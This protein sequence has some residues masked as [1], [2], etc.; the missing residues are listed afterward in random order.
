MERKI[1]FETFRRS[2]IRNH[3][4]LFLFLCVLHLAVLPALAQS[5]RVTGIV[6]DA[7]GKA[8][9]GVSVVVKGTTTGTTTDNEGR[10]SIEV[11]NSRSILVFSLIGHA[12]REEIVGTR[13]TVDLTLSES[14]S[15]LDEVVVI[16]YGTQKKRDVTGAISSINS[17]AIAERAPQ[18]VFEAIQG[19]IPGVVIAQESGRPGAS[20]SI[21]IRGIGTLEAGAEPLYVVDGAQGVNID[22]INPADIE[23]IE[24]L[25]D[26]ASAA[27]YGSAGGNGVIII[28]TKKGKEGKPKI[29]LRYFTSFGNLAHKVPQANAADRRLLDLKR[30]STG[31][32]SIP[33]DS[34]NP[35]Y[36][37][38]ND[39]QDLLTQTAVRHQIDLGISGGSKTANLYGSFGLIKDKGLIVNS[40]ADI[41][42]IRFNMDFKPNERFSFGS[43]I[44]GLYQRENRIDE[45]RTLQQAIQR[46][47]NF[48][49]WF[50]DG[51]LSG[52]IGGR[53][54]PLAE[55]LMDKNEYDIYD[56]SFYSYISYNFLKELKFTVDGNIR[57][58]NVHNLVFFP[59]LVSSANPLNNSIE[60]NSDLDTY[61]Q[62]QGYFNYNKSFGGVHNVTGVLGL[63][64]EQ[65]FSHEAEQSG[66]NLVTESVLTMNS[67]QVKNPATTFEERYFKMSYF[68]RLGYAYKGRYLINSNIRADAS[69]R[70]GKDNKWGI[71]PSA[72]IGWRFSDESF[73]AWSKRY[74][75][76]G[77]F[78]ISYGAIGND[79]IGPYDAIQRYVFGSNYYNGIS[80]VGPNTTFGNSKLAWESV[81]QFN[82][83]TD[84]TFLHGRISLSADYYNKTTEDL[85][86]SA[87]LP[88]NTGFNNVKV[89]VGS[90]QNKGFEFV[91]SGYPVRN[92]DFQWNV[93]YNMSINNNTVKELYNHTDLLPGS[94]NVWKVSE[95]GRLGDFYGY[96]ALGVYAYDQSN[97]WTPDYLHQLTPIF[98]NNV[99]SGYELD[100]KPYSGVVK[101]MYTNGL[102]SQGGDMIWQNNNLDSVIDDND[103]MILGN[104]QPKWVAGLNNVATYKNFTLSFSFYISW[105]GNIY[106][107][108]RAQLNLNATTNVTPEP[109]Y[110]HGAWWHQGDVTI[111]PIA[112]N[113]SLG[114]GRDGSSLYME[115]ATYI[116]LR[117]AKLS[118]E[119]P[120]KIAS[121][122]KMDAVSVFVF[123]NN[124]LTW[125][126]YKWYDPEISLG[127]ALTPGFDS[128]RFPRKREFG[129]GININF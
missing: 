123:G 24:V 52:L 40:W 64:G 23:S 85:L 32:T 86:Y 67:A 30:S 74:L 13:K 120:K 28:T 107:N 61:W 110:I 42:R 59:K 114:N 111:Y 60:D 1:H 44:Q 95:G 38:D 47:P 92:K 103:R 25:R 71:F 79:R 69:S 4:K 82:V 12:D 33:S 51:T 3:L 89:N 129:G 93:S 31:T 94:P 73:M 96:Q 26:A 10:F 41:A 80:G 66:S 113:N 50:Q 62:A 125:T 55:A 87:P 43:R 124:L 119:L 49:M 70:F 108:A 7:Q 97:A 121:R 78:R 90:I 35:G 100:G 45:G 54:N 8:L 115:D 88:S 57:M 27:I 117:N 22:G 101:K 106:N 75:D 18:N 34:L 20:S 11:P 99:F 19:Q 6:K 2:G 81:K 128:G 91:L 29:D 104:A 72:S 126:N 53:R 46:P 15:N 127:S 5:S 77:K 58:T 83:G 105:G 63:A 14:A 109:D 56:G 37:A 98:V 16:G 17:K 112:R 21:R 76:D 102:V 9:P 118:Y 116:R 65:G 36:N 68:A 39:Y 122:I 48:R 84:L